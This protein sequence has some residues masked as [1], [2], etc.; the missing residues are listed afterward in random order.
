MLIIKGMVLI[1]VDLLGYQASIDNECRAV[2]RLTEIPIV[3]SMYGRS[4]SRSIPSVSSLHSL[5]AEIAEKE[6][7]IS[8]QRD[9]A[10]VLPARLSRLY[11]RLPVHS[12]LRRPCM[13]VS[14][15]KQWARD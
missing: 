5:V 10:V 8:R 3:V 14:P 7:F 12:L 9:K 2:R 6:V 15:D 4:T 13:I 11:P 1:E